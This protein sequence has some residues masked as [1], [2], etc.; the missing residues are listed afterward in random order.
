MAEVGRVGGDV[1]FRV[2]EELLVGLDPAPDG[3]AAGGEV[4][5]LAEAADHHADGG[6]L[7]F[8]LVGRSDLAV[9]RVFVNLRLDLSQ[10]AGARE[11]RAAEVKPRERGKG[12]KVLYRYVKEGVFFTLM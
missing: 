5:L 9:V 2:F 12:K 7:E 4:R 8:R 3:L 6:G 10:A 11:T 1:A